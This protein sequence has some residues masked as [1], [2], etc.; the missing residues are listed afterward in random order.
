MDVNRGDKNIFNVAGNTDDCVSQ[1]KVV[2]DLAA[3][4]GVSMPRPK[5][6]STPET[7]RL[8]GFARARVL[9]PERRTKIAKQAAYA[10]WYKFDST[11]E[12]RIESCLNELSDIAGRL[13]KKGYLVQ[14]G[15]MIMG[16]AQ[17]EKMK[18]ALALQKKAI[19]TE[20][21]RRGIPDEF[22]DRIRKALIADQPAL[23]APSTNGHGP[24]EVQ[25]TVDK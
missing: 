4:I 3:S 2:Y 15:Q 7:A 21:A 5:L 20:D 11:D 6:I 24:I 8:G 16:M 25:F 17:F 18:I 13:K 1:R 14:A 10:R 12:R 23:P 22:A 9:S 19:A